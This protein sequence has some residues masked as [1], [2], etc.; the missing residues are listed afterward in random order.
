MSLRDLEEKAGYYITTPGNTITIRDLGDKRVNFVLVG[1]LDGPY[2][3]DYN[4]FTVH[5]RIDS[6]S[7]DLYQMVKIQ[8]SDLVAI[9]VLSD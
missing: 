3:L 7:D 5:Y 2:E 6:D 1:F 9:G 4:G 8:Y